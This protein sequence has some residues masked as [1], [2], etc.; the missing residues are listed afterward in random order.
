MRWMWIIK[1]MKIKQ[2]R[3]SA[4]EMVFIVIKFILT[5]GKNIFQRKLFV[6]Y[7]IGTTPFLVDMVDCYWTFQL[8]HKSVRS[9]FIL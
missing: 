1:D 6:C 7:H 2:I 5:I 9:C 4:G 3:I 8:H